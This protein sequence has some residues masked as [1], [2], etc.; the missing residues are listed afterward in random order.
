MAHA[1]TNSR[2]CARFS[3]FT[4]RRLRGSLASPNGGEN[5]MRPRP[6]PPSPPS[7]PRASRPLPPRPSPARSIRPRGRSPQPPARSRAR[8]SV[9][10]PPPATPTA[11]SASAMRGSYSLTG[12]LIGVSGKA[13]IEIATSNITIDLN[14]FSPFG[15]AGALAAIR[16]EPSP[17]GLKP[18]VTIRDG[19]INGWP[20]GAA[21]AS[22]NSPPARCSPPTRS[23]TSPIDAAGPPRP[24]VP[25]KSIRRRGTPGFVGRPISRFP[26]AFEGEWAKS[27][28]SL[29]PRW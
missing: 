25:E 27:R 17:A 6:A 12:N 9:R 15:V 4:S 20:A 19:H 14:G 1:R 7:S 22:G 3:P 26:A 11:C 29:L 23:P 2:A 16:D 24:H 5:P 8:R 18:S 10:P 28:A 13:G 21:A